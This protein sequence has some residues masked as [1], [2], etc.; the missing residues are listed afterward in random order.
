[1]KPTQRL[2]GWRSGRLAVAHHQQVSA[3]AVDDLT[4]E[5]LQLHRQAP[6][7]HSAPRLSKPT[8]AM[9][10][11]EPDRKTCA[12]QPP[13][14]CGCER[15]SV[16]G[17]PGRNRTCDTWFRKPVLYPLSYRGGTSTVESASTS[18]CNATVILRCPWPRRTQRVGWVVLHNKACLT[19]FDCYLHG[20]AR[21]SESP[22]SNVNWVRSNRPSKKLT[23]ESPPC[24]RSFPEPSGSS[25][26]EA[27]TNF[28]RSPR[29]KRSGPWA[30]GRDRNDQPAAPP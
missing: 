13:P 1:M 25:R 3:D 18:A 15:S 22:N 17:A 29:P 12:P 4:T 27:R 9:S 30:A 8:S 16:T 24:C 21:R 7:G 10:I 5:S 23:S 19:S 20:W 26:A 6:P 14:T 2:R 11:R 28:A